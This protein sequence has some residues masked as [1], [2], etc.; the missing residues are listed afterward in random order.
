MLTHTVKI[1]KSAAQV[2]AAINRYNEMC[3]RAHH[4]VIVTDG[5]DPDAIAVLAR[6][7]TK[8]RAL[9]FVAEMMRQHNASAVATALAHWRKH[10]RTAST[11]VDV[12]A[13]RAYVMAYLWALGAFDKIDRQIP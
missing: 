7:T 12:I 1:A 10:L 4:A 3:W 13:A 5:N 6:Y 8:L 2:E 11:P 9:E